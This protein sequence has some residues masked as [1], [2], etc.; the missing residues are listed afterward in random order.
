MNDLFFS[1]SVCFGDPHSSL[2]KG[3]V[4]GALCLLVTVGLVL[5]VIGAVAFNWAR[6]AKKTNSSGLR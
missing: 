5:S 3:A 1:C 2:S 4:A 6:R